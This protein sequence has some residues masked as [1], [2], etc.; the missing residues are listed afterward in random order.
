[1]AANSSNSFD[2]LPNE[3]IEYIFLSVLYPIPIESFNHVNHRPSVFYFSHTLH[4]PYLRQTF[5]DLTSLE[6]VC[7][8]FYNILRTPTFWIRK[9][10]CDDVSL[11]NTQLAISSNVD[12]RRLYF[13]NPFHP[14]YNRLDFDNNNKIID[15]YEQNEN[16]GPG[17]ALERTP[18]GSDLLYDAFGLLSSCYATSYSWGQYQRNNIQLLRKGEENVSFNLFARIF[19]SLTSVYV[20]ISF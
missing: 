3:L 8:R 11:V 10:Q 13:S 2:C 19:L 7:R 20:I 6:R 4:E 5:K 14:D 1:M 15:R 16:W 9:C 12:F 18:I 17:V